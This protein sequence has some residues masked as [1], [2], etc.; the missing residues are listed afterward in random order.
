MPLLHF[1]GFGAMFMTYWADKFM[2]MHCLIAMWMFSND[3]VF[4]SDSD[5][6]FQEATMNNK[7]SPGEGIPIFDTERGQLISRVTR[8]QVVVLFAFFVTGYTVVVMRSVLFEYVPALIR[9]VFPGLARLLEKPRVA[10]GIPNYFDAATSGTQQLLRPDLRA[11]YE[12][13]LLNRLAQEEPMPKLRSKRSA[14]DIE[15]FNQANWIVGC[16]SYAISDNKEYVAKL[17][18]D[19]HL[20]EQIP[21]DQIF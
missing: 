1:I 18:I 15:R 14:S 6:T 12:R 8:P 10:K 21:L 3:R 7:Y 5:T 2:L 19:S 20:S 11:K 13:A 4:E 17:A 9:S 16:P